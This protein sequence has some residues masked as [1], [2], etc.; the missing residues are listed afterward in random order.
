MVH[1]KTAH[2][3]GTNMRTSTLWLFFDLSERSVFH[4]LFLFAVWLIFGSSSVHNQQP[5]YLRRVSLHNHFITRFFTKPFVLWQAMPKTQNRSFSRFQT[6][7]G[8]VPEV[9]TAGLLT[10]RTLPPSEPGVSFMRDFVVLLKC[11]RTPAS[12]ED[13]PL[14]ICQ[15][16]D[17]QPSLET[18]LLRQMTFR[19]GL[20]IGN[21]VFGWFVYLVWAV[22]RGLWYDS[23][24]E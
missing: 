15:K 12:K 5:A 13:R 2:N 14:R 7:F 11:W 19:M 16:C 8:K 20:G 1:R 10:F 22:S 23:L 18:C 21:W 17:G 4:F 3:F 6:R 24:T 9:L